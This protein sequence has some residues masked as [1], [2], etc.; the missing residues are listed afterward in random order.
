MDENLGNDELTHV[1]VVQGYK[2]KDGKGN[3]KPSRKSFFAAFF[4]WASSVL[5]FFF[6]F[7]AAIARNTGIPL[8]I[9]SCGHR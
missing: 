6:F 8:G 7:F 9:V 5:F 3:L 1:A 2:N 4:L